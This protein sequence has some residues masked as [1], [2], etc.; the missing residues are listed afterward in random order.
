MAGA[1]NPSSGQQ[2][3]NKDTSRMLHSESWED[4]N[5][6]IC[7]ISK[8]TDVIKMSA[9]GILQVWSVDIKLKTFKKNQG[10]RL[11]TFQSIL[12]KKINKIMA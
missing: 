6:V 2:T 8:Q 3:V 7:E 12:E 4:A 5:L 11:N 10:I 1:E 9:F